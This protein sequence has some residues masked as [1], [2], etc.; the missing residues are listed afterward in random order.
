M[1]QAAFNSVNP[2]SYPTTNVT[3]IESTVKPASTSASTV[4]ATTN[5]TRIFSSAI[6]PADSSITSTTSTSSSTTYVPSTAGATLVGSTNVNVINTA[7]IVSLF[8]PKA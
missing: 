3:I 5:G 2:I 4:K 7:A 1:A 6:K 8:P